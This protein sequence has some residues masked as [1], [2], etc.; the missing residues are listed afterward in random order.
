V[1][2]RKTLEIAKRNTIPQDYYIDNPVGENEGD[3]YVFVSEAASEKLFNSIEIIENNRDKLASSGDSW[4]IPP[5]LI[6]HYYEL[7]L[8]RM[9]SFEW[10]PDGPVVNMALSVEQRF[11]VDVDLKVFKLRADLFD[12]T[13]DFKYEFR[14]S[15]VLL[16]DDVKLGFIGE[17]Y[18]PTNIDIHVDVNIAGIGGEVERAIEWLLNKIAVPIIRLYIV[19]LL[20]S[21]SWTFV[22]PIVLTYFQ[23]ALVARLVGYVRPSPK[24]A[25]MAVKLVSANPR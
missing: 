22:A 20:I 2:G 7:V 9:L 21:V 1:N 4:E 6:S 23:A 19:F 10:S 24:E 15:G 5:F 17:L 18:D 8:A 3:V 16:N 14:Y 25:T 13:I 11:H 12:T